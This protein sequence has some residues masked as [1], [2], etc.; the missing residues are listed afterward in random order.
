M[1]SHNNAHIPKES[2]P[3]WTWYAIEFFI[4]FAIANLI[5]FLATPSFEPMVVTQGF[6]CVQESHLTK[7]SP[8]EEAS[9]DEQLLNWIFYSI[10]A[11]IFLTWYI[12]IR[13]LILKKKIL[14]GR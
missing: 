10:V 8:A 2:W 13:G 11:A 12:V 7:C 1:V 3:H 4:V 14:E 6:D 9:P 5:A